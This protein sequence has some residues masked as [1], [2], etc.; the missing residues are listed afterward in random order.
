MVV[1]VVVVVV[2]IVVET[3][4]GYLVVTLSAAGFSAIHR[5][6]LGR[7]GQP[8][9]DDQALDP[10]GPRHPTGDRRRTPRKA[11]VNAQSPDPQEV[12]LLG[13]SPPRLC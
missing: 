11:R 6:A 3:V 8:L 10:L 5:S 9:R 1:V 13:A 4:N 7:A 2:E 12:A